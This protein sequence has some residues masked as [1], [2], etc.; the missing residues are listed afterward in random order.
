MFGGILHF[1]MV[2][3]WVKKKSPIIPRHKTGQI[4]LTASNLEK[5]WGANTFFVKVTIITITIFPVLDIG[6]MCLLPLPVNLSS[7]YQGQNQSILFSPWKKI[8]IQ[9][10]F[11]K[12]TN[13]HAGA[14][15]LGPAWSAG[16][17]PSA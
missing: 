14:D 1:F 2:V 9:D 13:L 8:S 7:F 4:N 10:K 15:C 6:K 5:K 12:H 3:W 17:H 11:I 16:N